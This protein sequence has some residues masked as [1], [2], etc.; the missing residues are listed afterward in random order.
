MPDK[1]DGYLEVG[2]NE[3]GEVVINHQRLI[4]DAD[5][6]GHII[7]S[8]TKSRDLAQS[9]IRAADRAEHQRC[10]TIADYES[11]R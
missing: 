2:T 6:D 4:T 5:G 8:P 7:V 11:E 10:R 9:L 1:I 3:H